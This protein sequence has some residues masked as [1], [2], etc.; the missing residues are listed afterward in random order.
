M[1]LYLST[2]RDAR[3]V[4]TDDSVQTIIARMKPLLK[5]NDPAAAM[6]LMADHVQLV[7]SGKP[8]P[9]VE[10][11]FS[12]LPLLILCL[13]CVFGPLA[14]NCRKRRR[15]T[16]VRD[17]L[18]RISALRTQ[19]EERTRRLESRNT[20]PTDTPAGDGA[21]VRHRTGGGDTRGDD[22][23]DGT[24]PTPSPQ[25]NADADA[26]NGPVLYETDHCPVCLEDF[27]QRTVSAGAGG[28]AGAGAAHHHGVAT[29]SCGHQ[30][31]TNCALKVCACM[32]SG[33]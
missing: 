5:A 2:G 31:C 29:L 4:V 17:R 25:V 33:I 14:W 11:D 21:A 13:G 8:L 30:L 32:R 16:R 23:G 24:T 9:E 20:T 19:L 26:E 10:P 22:G 28:G 6:V 7:A 18:E 3:E 12:G 27:P 15:F 1:Q